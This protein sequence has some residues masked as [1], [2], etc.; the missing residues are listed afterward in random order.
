M[1]K[2]FCPIFVLFV[3]VVCLLSFLY[4]LETKKEFQRVSVEAERVMKES[5][6]INLRAEEVIK[7]S[8]EGISRA[9]KV[10]LDSVEVQRRALE[11]LRSH[12]HMDERTYLSDMKKLKE[13]ER[14]IQEE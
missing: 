7:E 8:N 3:F 9:K 12:N 11:F 6:E 10:M 4:S 2:V 5:R 14:R 1:K 13:L